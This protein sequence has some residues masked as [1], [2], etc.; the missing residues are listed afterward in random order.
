MVYESKIVCNQGYGCKEIAMWIWIVD[1]SIQKYCKEHLKKATD[2]DLQSRIIRCN[3]E[4]C[5]E[6]SVWEGYEGYKEGQTYCDKH[7]SITLAIDH[8]SRRRRCNQGD[9]RDF[10]IWGGKNDQNYC[11]KHITPEELK[12]YEEEKADLEEELELIEKSRQ[13]FPP[14]LSLM[15]CDQAD[16][17]NFSVWK[18]RIGDR[19]SQDYC[20]KHF[21]MIIAMEMDKIANANKKKKLI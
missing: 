14:E 18:G 3:Q 20:D 13:N 4:D 17:D 15:T 7:L 11:E 21:N 6:L 19:D 9:C 1:K 2:L 8:E 5:N 10:A 12:D 16:C